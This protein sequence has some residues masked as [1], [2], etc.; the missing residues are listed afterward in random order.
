[1]QRESQLLVLLMLLCS[2]VHCQHEVRKPSALGIYFFLTDFNAPVR[3]KSDGI[4]QLFSSDAGNMRQGLAISYLR[5]LS[6]HFDL[7]VTGAGSFAD[8]P[9][10]NKPP[11]GSNNLL[12][13]LTTMVNMKLKTDKY[14]FTPY[15]TSGMGIS[16]YK[17]YYGISI[18]AGLGLQFNFKNEIYV[19]IQSHYA[20]AVSNNATDN[21]FHSIG[22]AGNLRKAKKQPPAQQPKL[23]PVDL[24]M[25]DRDGDG[26][27][28]KDDKCPTVP[29]VE[30]YAGCPVPDTDADGL[31]DEEDNCPAEL[32]VPKY[33]GCPI[34]DTD[35]DGINDEQDNCINEKGLRI[36]KGCP[37]VDTVSIQRINTAATQ[38]FFETGKATLLKQS[39]AALDTIAAILMNNP[40]YQI[41]IEGH[42][43]N[44]GNKTA[45]QILSENRAKAVMVYLL[46]KGMAEERMKSAGFG[47]EKPVSDNKNAKGRSMNR[48][49]E[50]RAQR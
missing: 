7:S 44:Q 17:E 2:S 3:I 1:M 43:D 14:L 19:L 21:I 30:R 4:G 18:P 48:R 8:Y 15:I 22:I 32:G 36:N 26:I 13:Q 45:N 34:P 50:I 29:G 10:K 11:F 33:Q 25:H 24:A 27:T 9:I 49:V 12:L 40:V 46:K 23:Q 5:G 16:K 20:F 39:F 38:I 41:S 42:T 35:G 47:Q 28:D 37:V 6:N 31:N